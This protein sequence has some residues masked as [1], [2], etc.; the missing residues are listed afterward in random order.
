MLAVRKNCVRSVHYLLVDGADPNYQDLVKGMTALHI[1]AVLCNVSIIK[2]LL[3]FDADLTLTDGEG[4]TPVDI[5]KERE[6]DGTEECVAVMENVMQLRGKTCYSTS[7]EMIL[8][9]YNDDNVPISKVNYYHDPKMDDCDEKASES[10]DQVQSK[11]LNHDLSYPLDEVTLLS[12]DGGGSRGAIVSYMLYHIEQRMR[13]LANNPDLQIRHYFNWYAGTSVGS[14]LALCMSHNNCDTHYLMR[15]IVHNRHHA[16]AGKRLYD[17]PTQDYFAQKLIGNHNIRDV[18]DP[19]V[20]I[21]TTLAEKDPPQ[22]IR[23]TNYREDPGNGR[24][25][26]AW[27]AG[28]ASGA[29]PLFFPSF[30][31]KYVDGGVLAINP[32]EHALHD[33]HVYDGRKVGLI[34]SLGTGEMELETNESIDLIKPRLTHFLSDIQNNLK[35]LKGLT[36]ILTANVSNTDDT[37]SHSK[38]W[39]ESQGGVY[40]RLSPPISQRIPL[41]ETSDDAFVLMFYEA[42]LHL[43][44]IDEEITSIA[45]SL[46]FQG[47]K[48]KKTVLQYKS[49]WV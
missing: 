11:L 10:N 16:L 25:W 5:A 29:A 42:Y 47:S 19:K 7:L 4:K 2:L 27:E 1:A 43:L 20:L 40:H 49:T 41:D 36:S 35:F 33:I 22:L 34:L 23:I 8:E 32:T 45:R 38:S 13:K 6:G 44:I 39:C 28:R 26:K 14:L 31:G 9:E 18:T 30:E 48:C 21:T 15:T 46:I 24:Q 12:L 17:G 37:V 3:A